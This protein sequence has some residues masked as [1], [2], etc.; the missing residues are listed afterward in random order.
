MNKTETGEC[1]IIGG[2]FRPNEKKPEKDITKTSGIYKITN[3]VNGKYYVGSS[4]HID[5][6]WVEHIKELNKNV[7]KNDYL[8]R[9]WNKYGGNN[10]SFV[11]VEKIPIKELLIIEQKYLDIAYVEQD[12]CYNL[13]FESNGG[14]LSE[15]S[16]KKI[17][18][19]AKMRLLNKNN[20]PMFG[21]HHST[22]TKKLIG[23]YHK[24]KI[25]STK[26]R[27]KKSKSMM[28]SN[29]PNYGKDVSGKL[30]SRFDHKTYLFTNEFTN[31]KFMGTCYDFY[32]K[33]N[34]TSSDT[35]ALK[36][37]KIK[38]YKNWLLA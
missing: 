5:D 31:E 12:K 23:S 11:V 13:N 25:I 19:K 10:F 14:E 32:K 33:Y 8:Q 26:Q 20:H 30:N 15:Y 38:S 3:R 2:M 35:S 29:N 4:K 1:D 27:Q 7:H 18:V 28:G 22:K 34:F 16:R 21:K 6:R 17:G 9:S 37:R 24:G 36:N